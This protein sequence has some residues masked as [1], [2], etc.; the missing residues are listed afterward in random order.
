MSLSEKHD[1]LPTGLCTIKFTHQDLSE[2]HHH[3]LFSI[4]LFYSHPS[5]ILEYYI[6][7]SMLF[8]VV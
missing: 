2:G 1:Y 4:F 3:F 6:C 8:E 7:L 5:L